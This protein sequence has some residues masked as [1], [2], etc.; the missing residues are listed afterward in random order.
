MSDDI[1]RLLPE[2]FLDVYRSAFRSDPPASFLEAYEA[3][4]DTLY[5]GTGLAP[6]PRPGEQPGGRGKRF[7]EGFWFGA[8]DLLGFAGAVDRRVATVRAEVRRWGKARAREA[9]R[10]PA[11]QRD[12]RRHLGQVGVAGAGSPAPKQEE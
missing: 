4:K 3:L 11:P 7:H 2:G 10:G 12:R 5:F 9:R 6:E 1:R 8:G